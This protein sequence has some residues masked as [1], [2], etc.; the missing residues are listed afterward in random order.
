MNIIKNLQLFLLGTL[1]LSSTLFADSEISI[2]YSSANPDYKPFESTFGYAL[3]GQFN[4]ENGLFVSGYFNETDFKASGPFVGN[5]DVTSW[6]EV[7]IGYSFAHKWGQFYSLITFEKID[8]EFK[9][10]DGYGAHFGYRNDFAKDWT[11]VIQL[12]YI[13]TDFTDWQLIGKLFYSVSDTLSLTFGI[14]DYDNWDYT[15][16]EA[17][18]VFRF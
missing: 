3:S 6:S 5:V 13:D 17:G 12:G 8:T 15:N 9:T 16:Y 11:G 7:G 2:L 10:F 18:V 14:R 1:L 4:F